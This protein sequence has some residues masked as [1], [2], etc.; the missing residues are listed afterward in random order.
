MRSAWP[1]W[2]KTMTVDEF[3]ARFDADT[4]CDAMRAA[5]ELGTC[6]M[7]GRLDVANAVEAIGD[8]YAA[9]A[10]RALGRHDATVY[11][12][13]LRRMGVKR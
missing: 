2:S 7:M 9:D 4:V 6:N 12:H 8:D 5:R 1:R 10:L 3:E 11:V 13:L